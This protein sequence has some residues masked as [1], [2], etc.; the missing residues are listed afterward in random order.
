MNI[1]IELES[2]AQGS[3]DWTW[4]GAD[5]PVGCGLVVLSSSMELLYINRQA[6]QLLQLPGIAGQGEGSGTRE[7]QALPGAI[8]SLFEEL[9]HIVRGRTKAEDWRQIEIT[10]LILRPLRRL[11]L[12][13]C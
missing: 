8:T 2:G 11:L 5:A 7:Q 6:V 13:D 12:T 10:S 4:A 1:N 9:L 3:H